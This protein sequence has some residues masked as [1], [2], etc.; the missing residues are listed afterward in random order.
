MS[1]KR[2]APAVP[3]PITPP[4]PADTQNRIA[5]ARRR[6]LATGG[7]V[8]TFLGQAAGAPGN[9]PPPGPTLTGVK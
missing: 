6:R 8:S 4:N 9:L 5:T 7:A 3:E 2:K 1:F